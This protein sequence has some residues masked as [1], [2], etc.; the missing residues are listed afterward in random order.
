MVMARD[1]SRRARR[2]AVGYAANASAQ[3]IEIND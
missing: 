3:G 2:L 1:P